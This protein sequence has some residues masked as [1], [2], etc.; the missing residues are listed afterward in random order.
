MG[1][2]GEAAPVCAVARRLKKLRAE[3]RVLSV[4]FYFGFLDACVDTWTTASCL[5]LSPLSKHLSATVHCKNK[6]VGVRPNCRSMG[7]DARPN[8]NFEGLFSKGLLSKIHAVLAFVARLRP[9]NCC[10]CLDIR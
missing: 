1:E 4:Q 10:T 5:T 8:L 7:R 6:L 3:S 2:G 9:K